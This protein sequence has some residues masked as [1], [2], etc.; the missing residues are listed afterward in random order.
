MN[1]TDLDISSIFDWKLI[2]G[3]VCGVALAA[4]AVWCIVW[5]KRGKA[6]RSGKRGEKIVAK[7]LARLRKKD[8]I[9]L[10]DLM[11][12]TA[13]GKT[14]QIDHVVVS[15]RGIFVIETKNH[16]GRITGSEQ[17]QYWQQ[18]LSSQSRGFYNPILQNRSHLRAVRRH[19][20]KMDSE[21]F[22]TM[23]VFTEAWRLD[24]KADDIIIERSLLPDRHL[25]RTLIPEEEVRKCWWRPWRSPVVLDRQKMVTRIDGMLNEMKRRPRI[26]GRD[27]M[28]EIAEKLRSVNVTDSAARKEHIDYAKRTSADVSADIRKGIC[29]RCGAR[30]IVRK[31]DRGEFVGCSNYPRCRFTCS[32]DR[33]RH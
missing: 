2:I 14:S 5:W 24:I 10:N 30:L 16:A 9:V 4:V 17:A 13:N 1:L 11:L 3:F 19:L 29:P 12:P 26:L 6:R 25:K 28:R 20:P 31:S 32:I 7:E 27:S 15:T 23:V 8:F 21:L 33:L 18:H 22:S